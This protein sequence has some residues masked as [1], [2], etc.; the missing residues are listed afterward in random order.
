M[1]PAAQLDGV[2]GNL[3]DSHDVAVLLAEEH[4]RAELA[5][6]VDRRL[7]DVHRPVLEDELV[8][9]ALDG[10]ALF[11]TER[12]VVREVEAQL[13]RTHRRPR[14]PDVLAEHLA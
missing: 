2:A 11:R 3:H 8:H 1:R 5:R 10:V 13:V 9:A 6:L 4:R 14:L 7:E 12:V